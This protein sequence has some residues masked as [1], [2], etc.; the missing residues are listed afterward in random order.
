MSKLTNE[1]LLAVNHD[2]GNIMISASAGSGKTHVMIERIIRLINEGKA[3]VNQILAVT[4]TESAAFDMKEKLKKALISE[5]N[6]GR[7]QLCDQLLDVSCA[8]ISTLHAFCSRLI[9]SYFFVAGV[10]PDYKIID[11]AQADL[12]KE[13]ALNVTFA[14]LY[15]QNQP[16]FRT[17]RQRY[18]KK[19]SDRELREIILK[20]FDKC[21]S[22]KDPKAMRYKHQNTYNGGDEAVFE[23]IINAR[24]LEVNSIKKALEKTRPEL[25][26]ENSVKGVAFVDGIIEDID[27]LVAKR[28]AN[29]NDYVN[30]KQVR[31]SSFERIK[32]FAFLDAKNTAIEIR[33]KLLDIISALALLLKEHEQKATY[34]KRLCVETD[35]LMQIVDLFDE[36]YSKLKRE[37]NVLDFADLEHFTLKI[38]EDESVIDA[39]REQYKYVFVDE[40]QD[41]NGVQEQ[42]IS[43]ISEDNLFMVGDV[44]QSIYGFRG[45]NPDIFEQKFANMQKTGQT[46]VNL[47]HNFRSADKILSSVNKIFGYSMTKDFYGFDYKGNA[48]LKNGKVYPDTAQGRTMLH[49]L[50]T[51]K[52]EKEKEEVTGLY[53]VLTE[54]NKRKQEK[55]VKIASLVTGIIKEELTKKYYDTKLG[56]YR[57]ITF[58]DIVILTRNRENA[59]V[60]NLV[61]G[62]IKHGIPVNSEVKQNVCDFAEVKVLI[63]LLKLIDCFKQDI[64]LASVLKSAFGGFSDEELA[65]IALNYKNECVDKPKNSY[66]YHAYYYCLNNLHDSLGEK[67]IDFDK[68]IADLR[69]LADFI[70]AKAVLE[71]FV[72]DCDYFAHVLTGETGEQKLNR[73]KFFIENATEGD[74]ALTVKEFLDKI[75]R[76]Q[77]SFN[78][79]LASDEE[80]VKVMTIHASKGLEFP[81]VIVVGL[82]RK[83]SSKETYEQVYFDRDLGFSIHNFNDEA[84][85][86]ND[87]FL[88][89]L[90]KERMRDN[91]LKEE[92]RLL[93]VAFTRA[94]YSLH[95]TVN[96]EERDFK[97]HFYGTSKFT[98]Y[99]PS[100]IDCKVYDDE[101]EFLQLTN[102]VEKVIIGKTDLDIEQKISER[103]SFSYPYLADC[104]LPLKANVTGLN[105]KQKEEQA[106]TYKID[107]TGQTDREKGTLAHKFLEHYDFAS[108]KTFEQQVDCILSQGIMTSKELKCFDLSKI[109]N[110]LK[111]PIFSKIAKMKLLKEKGFIVALPANELLGVNT[112][113]KML[114]QGVVDLLAIDDEKAY[115]IDYKYSSLSKERLVSS[116]KTQL[117]IYSQAVQLAMNKKVEKRVIVNIFSGEVV[118]V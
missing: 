103:F 33:D 48:D 107:Y 36:N 94:S 73:V 113:Q 104:T 19:R 59:Y 41:V 72:N 12:L 110:A 67:L 118:E 84:R 109:E 76:S 46:T 115:V 21:E 1:Q 57:P 100:G 85:T 4:F 81:V 96:G 54:F 5:I 86:K 24:I 64:P 60:S 51:K 18:A 77:K 55:T 70:G 95:M 17:L 102:Q 23:Q 65:K 8:D 83:T 32:T 101:F 108:D 27:D 3:N 39:I 69:Y 44:K 25:E 75:E 16:I 61:T 20:I 112:N 40:Y 38:L 50:P 111:N 97:T 117:D 43:L 42:I 63:D 29:V 47:N 13:Q 58:K 26:N 62:L 14:S 35:Q 56:D 92:L 22:E 28:F 79:A 91:R 80:T 87:S 45:C 31:K 2:K 30:Y 34:N 71:K 89:L 98:D 82:E 68:R 66:F 105:Q 106:P 78:F 10:N 53:N 11:E 7:D 49:I 88:R 90:I 116:Y 93:Y 37:E 9:R 6:K 52:E 99:I 114:V 74:K 15:E